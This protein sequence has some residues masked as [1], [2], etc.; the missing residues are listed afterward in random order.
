M[1]TAIIEWC[2]SDQ[3]VYIEC[4]KYLLHTIYQVECNDQQ[5]KY[6]YEKMKID[7]KQYEIIKYSVN[8]RYFIY[9][10]FNF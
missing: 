5:F 9:L 4:Y 3:V 6:K 2:S 7:D 1:L 10:K 8:I